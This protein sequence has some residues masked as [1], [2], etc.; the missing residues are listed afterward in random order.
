VVETEGV[1]DG[2]VGEVLEVVMISTTGAMP[3]ERGRQS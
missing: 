2:W 3:E 1:V